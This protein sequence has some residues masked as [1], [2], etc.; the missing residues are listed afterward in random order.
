VAR[1]T[2]GQMSD[3]R[4][5]DRIT[6]SNGTLTVRVL[7][8][9]AILNDLR[10]AGVGYPLTLGCEDAGA[11]LEEMAFFGAVVGPVANRIAG[12]STSVEGRTYEF[13]RNENDRTTLHGGFTGTY[14]RLW[15]IID[16]TATALR[17]G[18]ELRDGEGGFPGNRR[19]EAEYA[20][21]GPALRLTLTAETDAPTPF[22]LAHH[23]YWNMDGT[24]S[25]AGQRLSI[26]AD[27]F[28]PVDDDL[29]PTGEIAPVAGTAFDFRD[30]RAL[31]PAGDPEYDH[32]FCLSDGQ[33][34]LRPVLSL[35]GTSGITM[36]IS[37]TEPGLQFFDGGRL[38]GTR[39]G[40]GGHPYGPYS[41]IALEPQGW[42][43]APNQPGFPSV[44]LKP[45]ETYRQ[46]T[47]F[48]FSKGA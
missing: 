42:P 11:Y 5:I 22:N 4:A 25:V 48:S 36:D 35:T 16:F 32:N 27:H 23:G 8:L 9:G 29:I 12:A 44:L 45:G 15:S 37:T 43:D 30:G 24:P 14:A 3:G 40:L 2:F 28:L 38:A 46:E 47:V 19:I 1:E 34:P 21:D 18:L 17:L 13:E 7:T 39:A 26:A 31:R 41:G 20:L 10:L 6:L 33:R